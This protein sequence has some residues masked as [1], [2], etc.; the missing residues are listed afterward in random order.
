MLP[1]SYGRESPQGG[2]SKY[3]NLKFFD[4]YLFDSFLFEASFP[5]RDNYEINPGS[6]SKEKKDQNE[7]Y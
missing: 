5:I 6:K 1:T 4:R 2:T 7:T 3:R